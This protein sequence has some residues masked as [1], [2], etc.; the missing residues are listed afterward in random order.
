MIRLCPK[1]LDS[2]DGRRLRR[3]SPTTTAFL[4]H[5]TPG[6]LHRHTA[7]YSGFVVLAQAF[8]GLV[9]IGVVDRYFTLYLLLWMVTSDGS[10]SFCSDTFH[11]YSL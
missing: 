2:H 8:T 11:I 4:L 7:V 6:A 5:T 9:V 10:G 3:I 1:Q